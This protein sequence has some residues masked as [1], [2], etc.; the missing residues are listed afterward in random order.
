MKKLFIEKFSLVHVLQYKYVYSNTSL[1]F[2]NIENYT[3][4]LPT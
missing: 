1:K 2:I 4:F 3:Y